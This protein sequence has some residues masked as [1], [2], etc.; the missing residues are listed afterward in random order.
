MGAVAHCD[1]VGFEASLPVTAVQIRD[2]NNKRRS[3]CRRAEKS[4][5]LA[6]ADI[7]AA[8]RRRR[9]TRM[10][11]QRCGCCE[12]GGEE[13]HERRASK[14]KVT[15]RIHQVNMNINARSAG[16][17]SCFLLAS[18]SPVSCNSEKTRFPTPLP[19]AGPA[20]AADLVGLAHQCRSSV[21]QEPFGRASSDAPISPP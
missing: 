10:T 13:R 20:A 1:R 17:P 7:V 11:P 6:M 19:R 15:A 3:C 16:P 12:R 21:L 18:R 8:R 2:H 9:P 14:M 5:L 4:R